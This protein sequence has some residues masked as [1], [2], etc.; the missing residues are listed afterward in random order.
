MEQIPQIVR[1]RMESA[2]M[3]D[4]HPDPDL[5]SAL[6]ENALNQREREQV[7]QHLAVCANCREV[8]S[9]AQSQPELE[10]AAVAAGAVQDRPRG[11]LQASWLRWGAAAACVIVVGAAVLRYQSRE[12]TASYLPSPQSPSLTAARQAAETHPPSASAPVSE[13]DKLDELKQDSSR[14]RAALE[15]QIANELAVKRQAS[16]D[17]GTAEALRKKGSAARAGA[18]VGGAMFGRLGSKTAVAGSA[19]APPPF[20]AKVTGG[21]LPK[22]EVRQDAPQPPASNE[23]VA[24]TVAPASPTPQNAPVSTAQN[25]APAPPAGQSGVG[26]SGRQMSDFATTVSVDAQ[27][28][29]VLSKAANV[30]PRWTLSSDGRILMRSVDAGKTWQTVP[31]AG[32]VVLRAVSAVGAEVWTGGTGGALYHSSDAGQHWLP[33]KPTAGGETLA[34]DIVRIEF[35]D[36]MHGKVTTTDRQVW[37]T[38]DAGHNWQKQ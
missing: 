13:A 34:A 5:L 2:P 20:D 28:E 12:R 10:Y 27:S 14:E 9:L 19:A 15:Y 18:A 8:L 7:L 33:V 16:K 21:A 38:S 22:E 6:A 30:T 23:T 3:P 37:A 11:W 17:L 4:A 1:Q 26:A 35:S 31:V 29:A 32:N 25:A 36:A 24:V